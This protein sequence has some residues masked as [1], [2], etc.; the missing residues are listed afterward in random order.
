[1]QDVLHPAG[2]PIPLQDPLYLCRTSYTL[3][4]IL[5]PCRT[6]YIY[7]GCP[8][9][10]RTSYSPA[11]PPISMQDVLHP[12]MTSYTLQDVLHPAVLLKLQERVILWHMKHD[13]NMADSLSKKQFGFKRGT[14]TETALHKIAHTIERRIANKGYVLGTFLDIEGAFIMSHSKLFPMQSTAHL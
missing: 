13:H 5:F 6:S 14:S 4:D 7:E 1:M 3:Q 8:T 11:G 9:P 12:Y 10:C 2:H